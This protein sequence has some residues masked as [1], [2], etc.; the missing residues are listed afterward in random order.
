MPPHHAVDHLTIVPFE[1]SILGDGTYFWDFDGA[2]E[3]GWH[4]SNTSPSALNGGICLL[5]AQTIAYTGHA[6]T[7]TLMNVRTNCPYDTFV[8]P[9]HPW[10]A[11]SGFISGGNVLGA[12]VVGL[13]SRAFFS[14]GFVEEVMASSP[15]FFG[16]GM[17]GTNQYGQPFGG[18]YN[19]SAGSN[20]SG[21][22]AVR[23]GFTGYVIWLPPEDMGNIE[24][25][26]IGF[27][28]V[29]LGTRL[30]PDACGWG[31]FRSGYPAVSTYMVYKT[32]QLV[33]DLGPH[34]TNDRVYL[35]TG[36]YGGYP[37]I[38]Q[39]CRLLIDCNTPE[40]IEQRKP[41][42]HGIGLPEKDELSE[43]VTGKLVEETCGSRMIRDIAGEGD[44]FQV[45]FG[46]NAGGFGD[47]IK[48]NTRSIKQ[49]LDLGLLTLDRCRRIYCVEARYDADA[50]EWIIDEEKTAGLREKRRKERLSKG[51][52]VEKW[53]KKR[54][55][56]LVEGKIPPLLKKSY[57]GSLAKGERWPAEF[58]KFWCLPYDFSFKVEE[59]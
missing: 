41:L 54:R 1:F 32:Q 45:A 7:G 48:R 49:D 20:A 9:S 40:K 51:V 56:D 55:K 44:I 14:R 22:C 21:A 34:S 39:F 26:E 25:R 15:S 58:R 10:V 37:A 11:T 53:W 33:F 36:M 50:G 13:Q 38:N 47:P 42:V 29:T 6:N 18:L 19:S 12:L 2:G 17:T 3:W 30:L 59:V 27:P 28:L 52:P 24:V 8:N 5:L 46:G 4:P 31:K 35:D 57:N 16:W 43:N 23:D